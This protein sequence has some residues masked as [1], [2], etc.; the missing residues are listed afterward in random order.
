[1]VRNGKFRSKINFELFPKR[2]EVHHKVRCYRFEGE[3]NSILRRKATSDLISLS[4]RSPVDDCKQ[5]NK[6]M[7]TKTRFEVGVALPYGARMDYRDQRNCDRRLR[8]RCAVGMAH[9]SY[10]SY[11][12]L[13]KPLV[14]ISLAIL[15]A[16]N[17][18]GS[19]FFAAGIV[20]AI[21]VSMVLI[22]SWVGIGMGKYL[23]T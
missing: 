7:T 6:A 2:K 23:F 21:S 22:P 13:I 5:M 18:S 15:Y 16:T 10:F 9:G 19:A 17:C 1:M 14:S 11:N 3:Y 4:T 20:P 12:F 8:N